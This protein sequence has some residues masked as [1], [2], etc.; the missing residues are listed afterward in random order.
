MR[1]IRESAFLCTAIRL[2]ANYRS[3]EIFLFLPFSWQ[4]RYGPRGYRNCGP[5]HRVGRV[6]PAGPKKK[7][8]PPRMASKLPSKCKR[9][10]IQVTICLI[11]RP[12]MFIML[13][14]Y[15]I[16]SRQVLAA[17][18]SWVSIWHHVSK[19]M[20]FTYLTRNDSD[21]NQND[22]QL[23]NSTWSDIISHFRSIISSMWSVWHHFDHV[24]VGR[25]SASARNFVIDPM[26][27]FSFQ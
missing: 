22:I 11:N 5:E 14:Q 20:C 23:N 18:P 25:S 16:E 1:L 21:W 10:D 17:L 13:V 6:G 7:V 24:E 3:W 27:F 8:D 12:T 2:R 4:F 9:W 15:N 19:F 26:T